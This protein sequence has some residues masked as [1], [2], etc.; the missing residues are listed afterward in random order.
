M[1]IGVKKTLS[2]SIE[3]S[4]TD[5]SISEITAKDVSGIKKKHPAFGRVLSELTLIQRS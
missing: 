4:F 1:Q 5:T 3:A 2:G